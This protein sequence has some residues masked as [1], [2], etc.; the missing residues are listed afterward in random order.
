MKYHNP[1]GQEG[2]H[3]HQWGGHSSSNGAAHASRHLHAPWQFK[4][5]FFRRF[6]DWFW[7]LLSYQNCQILFVSSFEKYGNQ[8]AVQFCRARVECT[9]PSDGLGWWWHQTTKSEQLFVFF[10]NGYSR[11]YT[12]WTSIQLHLLPGYSIFGR[13][14]LLYSRMILQWSMASPLGK[15]FPGSPAQAPPRRTRQNACVCSRDVA[16]VSWAMV[17][18]ASTMVGEWTSAWFGPTSSP[19]KKK[20]DVSYSDDEQSVKSLKT[21]LF[22]LIWSK[23]PKVTLSHR[24]DRMFGMLIGE[25]AAEISEAAAVT[26]SMAMRW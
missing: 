26:P 11:P 8:V 18:L 23:Q 24:D 6:V 17:P 1:L 14:H 22:D 9:R 19:E 4:Y 12:P 13:S 7:V 15:L 5:C 21:T 2:S 3:L 20:Q 25:G 10:W 16:N